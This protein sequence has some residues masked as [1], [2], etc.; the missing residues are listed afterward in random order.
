MKF[1]HTPG[2]AEL[3]T[4]HATITVTHK[5]G[6]GSAA[7]IAGAIKHRVESWTEIKREMLTAHDDR[8][9]LRTELETQRVALRTACGWKVD[10]DDR[11]SRQLI[12]ACTACLLAGLAIGVAAMWGMLP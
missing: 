2:T 11:H 12:A 4:S 8:V 9:K 3:T 10:A 1:N 6:L 7:V 5:D